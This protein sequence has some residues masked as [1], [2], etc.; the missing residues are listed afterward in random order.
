MID[1]MIHTPV[2]KNRNNSRVLS[3]MYC[4]SC[5]QKVFS[6]RKIKSRSCQGANIFFGLRSFKEQMLWRNSSV[7]AF[8]FVCFTMPKHFLLSI[9]SFYIATALFAQKGRSQLNLEVETPVPIYQTERGFGGFIKGMYGLGRSAQLT[10]MTGISGFRSRRSIEQTITNT[11]LIPVLAGFK[12]NF[13]KF[14][15]EPQAGYGEL[16]GKINIGGDYARPS[17]GAFF[18]AIGAGYDHKR[19]NIGLR[20][21]QAQGAES[22]AAG[23]WH[24][25]DF[26]YT[27]IH[28]GYKLF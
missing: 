3:S 25:K 13:Q 17:V 11:R 18:W 22:V 21:Q 28:L 5:F 4:N 23:V 6:E 10:L 8:H 26:H 14:Y 2:I 20:F 12:Q 24:D 1:K 16:G 9:F 7:L 15:I 27:A 19:I